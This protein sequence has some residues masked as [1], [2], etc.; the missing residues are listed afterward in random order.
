[1]S[2]PYF[3]PAAIVQ[4]EYAAL[5]SGGITPQHSCIIGPL[6][7]VL[8][9]TDT[10]DRFHVNFGAYNSGVDTE[11]AYKAL[12]V[13]ALVM[14]E[15]V[16][17]RFEDVLA[18]Y[19][20]LSG[21]NVIERGS[22]ANY[23]NLP[24]ADGFKSYTNAA[25]TEFDRN[26]VFK[27]RDVTIGDRVKITSGAIEMTARVTGFVNDVIDA[28]VGTPS[29]A[30]NPSTQ[31]YAGSVVET[32]DQGTDHL[33][34]IFT[35]TTTYKGDITK[36]I[37][38]DVYVLECITPGAPATARFKVTSD[39]GDN[40]ANLV[41]VAFG[42]A[43]DVGTRG[44]Q[45][46]IA[47]TGSQAFV[48]GE[49]YTFT[50]AAA[51]TN[52]APTLMSGAT[53]YTGPFDT[54]YRIEVVKGG[55]WANKPQV[56]VTTSTGIDSGA[57]IV[58]DYNTTFSVG[59]YGLAV[60]FASNYAAT[61][62]GLVLGD[63]YTIAVTASQK[64]AVRTLVISSP[65]DSSIAEG[66]DLVV[67][68]YIYKKAVDL[69]PS[70]YPEFTSQ[71][72]NAE[73]DIFTVLQGI[74][75]QDPTW[76][77]NDGV[78]LGNLD[79]EVAT[80]FASYQAL[81]TDQVGV[82]RSLSDLSSVSAIL[83][84]VQKENPLAMGVQKA[85]ENSAGQPVYFVSIPTNDLEGYQSAL[86]VLESDPRPYFRVPMSEDESILDLV[87]AHINAEASDE[88]GNRCMG[89]VASIIPTTDALY[90]K[91]E[92]ED[93]W[94]GYVAIEPGSSPAIYTR[95]T[96]PGAE[97]LTDSIRPGDQ[98]R[99]NFGVDALGAVTYDSV[100]IDQVIDEE[101]IILQSPGFSA[102]VG[103][104]DDLQQIQIIRLLTKDEQAELARA[105]SEAFANR[106]IAN[107]LCDMPIDMPWYF[108]AAA[109][110]GLASSVVPHQPIT[111]Y[112]VNGFNDQV[113]AYRKFTPTQLDLIA[114]G[115]CLILTQDV[116]EGQVYVRHQLTTDRQDD[117]HAEMSITR[118]VDSVSGYLLQG[119][120][121]F[122]GKYNI[123]DNFIQLLDVG[124]RNRLDYLVATRVT[125]T[126]GSQL[127]DW[128]P[129][130]LIIT[131][132]P[133]AR[134]EVDLAVDADF[135]FPANR[136]VLKLRVKG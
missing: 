48:E 81:I 65:I 34:T 32:D 10:E 59:R 136:I 111:N 44:L 96:V 40:V 132:N 80:V 25:G 127:V 26:T 66:D 79:V 130:S 15:T 118:N 122:V 128:D 53:V 106:R 69:P 38:E 93:N 100:L 97:F 16:K 63:V 27:K 85:L 129:K 20:T 78:T 51:Y 23:L 57:A 82:L 108:G 88:K 114:S 107:V 55:L 61:Q 3:R 72:V 8:S 18:K 64:G 103:A 99:A 28:D 43:F 9:A 2:N 12:P 13:G 91:K 90:D 70:G 86:E 95:L 89:I 6:V 45:A 126:A 50:V 37:I 67:D 98:L 135:P 21:A 22:Q 41:S 73:A 112:T 60:K 1:M 36:G 54:V 84:K 92:N 134:T 87:T 71:T 19:A 74:Q 110:A 7:K 109:L 123:S 133:V 35:G 101:N 94:T 68:F 115:G 4:Q 76:L 105:K 117:R 113:A 14:T 33:P 31:A 11:Y 5:A 58:V 104:S 75:I 39:T 119:L 77:E 56:V 120:K 121:P 47:S 124:M 46:K 49:I 17:L 30:D 52:G 24:T 83:G 102:P 29:S 42:T 116:N 125:E 131:Q 62:G